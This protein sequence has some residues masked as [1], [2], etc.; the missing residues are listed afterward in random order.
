MK[1]DDNGI[2]TRK[3]IVVPCIVNSSLYVVAERMR[4]FGWAS[5]SRTNRA[6]TPPMMKKAKALTPYRMPI[7]LWSIVVNHDA[8]P[9]TAR[10]RRN[11]TD[12][13]GGGGGSSTTGG[14]RTVAITR[15][16]GMSWRSL[17][18]IQVGD[19]A[20]DLILRKVQVGHDRSGLGRRWIAQPCREVLV[21]ELEHGT[22][23]GVPALQVGEVG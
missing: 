20:V 14:S 17:Q 10:G 15:L 21:V 6:S 9:V 8:N 13:S 16:R 23:E 19:E 11:S 5:C 18:R 7:F 12:C 22:G 4:P 1:A 3:T 2:T